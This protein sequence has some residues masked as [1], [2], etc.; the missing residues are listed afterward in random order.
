MDPIRG[1]KGTKFWINV[2]SDYFCEHKMSNKELAE[3]PA[4]IAQEMELV[5]VEVP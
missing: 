5:E 4:A 1:Y 3:A 2:D